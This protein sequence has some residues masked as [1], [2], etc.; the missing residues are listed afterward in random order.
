MSP[1]RRQ[2]FERADLVWI[3]D[4]SHNRVAS[5]ER[6]DRECAAKPGADSSDEK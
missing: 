5:F 4:G 1:P 2:C 3:A 6:G